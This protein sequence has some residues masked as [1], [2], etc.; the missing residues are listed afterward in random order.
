MTPAGF[1]SR[2]TEPMTV[3]IL[4]AVGG[5]WHAGMSGFPY[6]LFIVYLAG[7]G[8][9]VWFARKRT[10][11]TLQTN[12]DVSDRRK[13]IR[14]LVLLLVFA[15]FLFLTILAWGNAGLIR[16]GIGFLLWLVGF[17]LITLRTKISGHVSVLM[18]SAGY[19]TAW[20]GI[21]GALMFLLVPPVAW[22][23]LLLKRHTPVEVIGAAVY[24]GVLLVCIA[25]LRLW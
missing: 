5:A 1:V 16:L 17:F 4:L 12:W 20:Y 8:V 23:R 24:T 18:F 14:L 15:V 13:R 3:L 9:A 25:A 19:L 2:L 7:I 6:L 10:M 11:K 22:S 21:P